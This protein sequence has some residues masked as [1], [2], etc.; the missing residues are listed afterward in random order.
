MIGNPKYGDYV[1]D[2]IKPNMLTR[3]FLLSVTILLLIFIVDLILGSNPL[4]AATIN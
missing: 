4:S 1:P 3:D 2:R